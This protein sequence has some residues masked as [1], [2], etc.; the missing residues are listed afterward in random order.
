MSIIFSKDSEKKKHTLEKKGS[1]RKSNRADDLKNHIEEIL[2][3][4]RDLEVNKIKEK[5]VE[6]G[7]ML[8][9]ST[10]CRYLNKIGF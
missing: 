7:Y 9:Y 5:L 3:E 2:G 4:D 8:G 1:E 10:L 6:K